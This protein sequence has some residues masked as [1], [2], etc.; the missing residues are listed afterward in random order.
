MYH[1]L[2]R[3]TIRL[4]MIAYVAALA[5]RI[6]PIAKGQRQGDKERGRQGAKTDSE[7][8][9]SP[10]LP[11]SQSPCLDESRTEPLQRTLW[12]V[13]CLLT[14][15]HVL[16]AF[17]VHHHWSH[18]AAYA[19]TA[20][21]SA[22]KVGIE[23]GGGIYFNYLFLVLWSADVVWWWWR[24]AKYR[25]RA[26]GISIF[27]HAYLAFIAFNATVVFEIGSVRYAGMGAIVGLGVIAVY[28]R[29]IS[30]SQSR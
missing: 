3:W 20:S 23:W 21:E 5:L 24:P 28:S 26:R 17:A 15:A 19:H 16:L 11:F 13:A 22:R 25:S 12:S 2:T 14:W 6:A 30:H 7:N 27:V 8:A 4:A 29:V 10:C 9:D 18:A 1:D